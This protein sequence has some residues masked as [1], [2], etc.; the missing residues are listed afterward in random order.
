MRASRALL[1]E[2]RKCAVESDL[3]V[4]V[5]TYV[6]MYVCMHVYMYVCMF[7]NPHVLN[8]IMLIIDSTICITVSSS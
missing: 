8:N 5:C 1:T 4:Y 2:P 6:C 3:G 7:L